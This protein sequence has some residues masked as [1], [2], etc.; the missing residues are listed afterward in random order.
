MHNHYMFSLLLGAS[1]LS[2][3]AATPAQVAPELP[4]MPYP[5][6][7]AYA[8]GELRL[9]PTLAVTLTGAT[10]SLPPGALERFAARLARQTGQALDYSAAGGTPLAIH[11]E[12][13]L[14][15]LRSSAQLD[16]RLES[17]QLQ[18]KGNG[19][20]L[21]AATHLGVRHGLHTL[22]Q[23]LA[24]GKRHLPALR[25]DDQ[26]RFGWRGL[27]LDSVRHFFSV[28][29]IKRQLDGMAAAKLNIFHWH[30]TDDQGW[31]LESRAFPKLH[32][33]ASGG[34]YYTREQVREVVA[35][36][37]ERGIQ[38]LP[39]IDMPGHSSAIAVAYPSLMSAPGPYE[40][41]E[42]WGVH[43]P[44]LN[45]A[46]EAVYQF[47]EAILTEVTELFPF[48]YVHIG[49]DEVD[50]T[51]WLGNPDIRAFM[52]R[53]KLADAEALH[54]YF[55][56]RLSAILSRL[57][58]K[59]I[60]WDEVLHPALPSTTAVQSWRG[61][62]ALGQAAQRG[63]PAIL[64]TGFYLDQPQPAG[65]HY[66]TRFFPAHDTIEPA[67]VGDRQHTWSF[68]MPRQRGAAVTGHFT[69]IESPANR[70]RGFI[71]FAGKSRQ[72]VHSLRLEGERIRFALDTWMGPV[73]ARLRR[74][75]EAL[76]GDMIVG[77]AAYPVSGEKVA[78]APAP[79]AKPRLTEADRSKILGGEIAL[80]S[81]LI[82]EHSIDLRLWPRA[83]A[84]AE[85]LWSPAERRDEASL[86]RRLPPVSTWAAQSLG[87]RHIEQ[88]RLALRRL[89]GAEHLAQ[90]QTLIEALEP[91]QYY[92]RH[93]EK[94]VHE[95]YSRRDPLDRLADSLPAES[96]ATRSLSRRVEQLLADPRD[97]ALAD[98][99]EKQL[100]SWRDSARA[101]TA[102]L[103]PE[104]KTATIH[105]QARR[106][107]T[108][109]EWGLKLLPL[110]RGHRALDPTTR[111]TASKALREAQAIVD[112]IVVA[113]AYPL[114]T[115]LEAIPEPPATVDWMPDS[116]FTSG[117]EGPVVGPDG[118]LYAVNFARQGTLGKVTGRNRG[119]RW[120]TLPAGSI[121]NSL[122]FDSNGLLWA[123]DYTGH[124]LIQLDPHSGDILAR[125]HEPRMHQ[126][127]DIAITRWGAIFA[128]DPDWA[129]S[130]G[131]L[132]RMD[133]DG[134]FAL[135]ETDMGT[136]NGIELSPDEQRLYVNES[137][138]RRVWV[139]RVSATGELSDKRLFYQF[140][141]HGLDGM[142][143]DPQGRLYIARYGAGEIAV[144]S[145]AG[146]LIAT[147]PLKG[148]YPTN[149]ALELGT[150][151]RAFVTLQE[152]GAIEMFELE[153]ESAAW[154][155]APVSELLSREQFEA[156]FPERNPFYTYDGLLDASRR[157]PAFAGFGDRDSRKRELAA[158]LANFA[159]ETG[160][161]VYVEEIRK[162]DYCSNR[163]TL[164]GICAEGRQYFGRGPIQLSWNGNYC[165]AGLAL[166]IDLWG[167]P[168]R[169]AEDSAIAWQTAL[170]Y[171]LTR[172]GPGTMTPHRAMSDG[173]GFGETIRSINGRLECDGGN[174]AQVESR[175]RHYQRI[176][177]LLGTTP[178]SNLR[179]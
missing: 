142:A 68:R 103:K 145:P 171:W 53:E 118:H 93:H 159:H 82:D 74:S 151:P 67:G 117:I 2:L 85:R 141:D 165:A 121:A 152:R 144:L 108:V 160:N 110:W 170:W 126:P 83:F 48:D 94:S 175:V 91:A 119:E 13:P 101:L 28:E 84:V 105:R 135:L 52:E 111:A 128:S 153:Q 137:V 58:R 57:D 130:R 86:Y 109:T 59:M 26:P 154:A 72:P 20:H 33:L 115:L 116:S 106:V 174:P 88:S 148:R 16:P 114:E 150:Q 149:I 34:H 3:G 63:H 87:L 47:A 124:N 70:H 31:R 61:P 65:Y 179:C 6:A 164:C 139:Y 27:M 104:G 147:V 177:K 176:I 5:V 10:E 54:A 129:N 127:N 102:A 32:E 173:H 168:A 22:L 25:I 169:V 62:D 138:Q 23:L 44:L 12:R 64:S 71:D 77:N 49:G 1:L 41:E 112:E 35:Y 46:D 24:D 8:E 133:P 161:L 97:E 38:V 51:H 78:Q 66:R 157:F 95:S 90:A 19:I 178:G 15:R 136:T 113:A 81:E 172:R 17:Y 134:T 39:E 156:L 7:V 107:E 18:V 50:P 55:N 21:H 79:L 42:R 125:H 167:E 45:P 123:A 14:A 140:D 89:A 36:A 131:Q 60:G 29:T 37:A 92:H 166:G 73:R 158:A 69:L 96:L 43:Q 98:A 146:R 100:A 9:E 99:I 132:W 11:I 30:L 76:G 155:P 120:L 4:L 80:W 75:G 122:R 143:T 162:G 56:R 40:P 163:D